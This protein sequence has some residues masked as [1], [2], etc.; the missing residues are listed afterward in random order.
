MMITL[1]VVSITVPLMLEWGRPFPGDARGWAM[2]AKSVPMPLGGPMPIEGAISSAGGVT[3]A[4]I[5]PDL[6]LRALPNVFVAGEMLDWEAPTGGYLLSGCLLT[7]RMAGM[8]ASTRLIE[9]GAPLR[10]R[11]P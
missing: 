1:L 2:L 3:E 6:E 10:K 5:T 8:A 11:Q 7:G 4:A 9:A